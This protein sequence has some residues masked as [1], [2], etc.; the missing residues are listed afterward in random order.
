MT[1]IPLQAVP[2]QTLSVQLDGARYVLTF[3]VAGGI[4]AADLT[5][6]E[7]VIVSGQRLVAWAPLLPYTHME[8]GNFAILTEND[9]LPHYAS[10][11]YT[12]T[13]VYVSP[14]ELA[15]LRAA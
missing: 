11:G 9:D 13:L 1:E 8:A 5:R 12:Q 7:V 4:M 14:A 6:D 15:D 2:N 10:F 3:K